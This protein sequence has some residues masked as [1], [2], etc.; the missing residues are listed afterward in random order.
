MKAGECKD[1]VVDLKPGQSLFARSISLQDRSGSL[2]AF[3]TPLTTSDG[4]VGQSVC[5]RHDV[6][7]GGGELADDS[8]RCFGF[9]GHPFLMF[10]AQSCQEGICT[11]HWLTAAVGK[12]DGTQVSLSS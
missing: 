8:P 10:L 12:C 3:T 11:T 5:F 1:T 4:R 6:P 7:M 2:R 9:D